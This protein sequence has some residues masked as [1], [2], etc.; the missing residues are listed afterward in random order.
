MI[1]SFVSQK[2]GVGK[3]TTAITVASGLALRKKKV[4]LIDLDAQCN[5]TLSTGSF[6]DKITI[7]DVLKGDVGILDAIKTVNNY[8]IIPGSPELAALLLKDITSLKKA[9]SPISHLYDFV[10]LDTPPHLSIMLINALVA[11]DAV[12]IVTHADLYSYDSIVR[13]METV[14]TIRLTQDCSFE[15]LGLLINRYRGTTTYQKAFMEFITE[16]TSNFEIKLFTTPIR[17]SITVQEALYNHTSIFDYAPRAKQTDDYK[18]LT[19]EILKRTE[20][21]CQKS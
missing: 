20:N 8:N 14:N 11:S 21:L 9:L 19:K 13:L 5:L 3:T 4:L 12:I 10:I 7:K 1:L 6:D 18:S 2:G 17:E 15:I 16:A